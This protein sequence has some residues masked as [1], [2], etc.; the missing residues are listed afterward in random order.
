MHLGLHACETIAAV[1]PVLLLS[2]YL[3]ERWTGMYHSA[4]MIRRVLITI[5]ALYGLF[6][7]AL[8]IFGV[9]FGGLDGVSGILAIAGVIYA[10]VQVAFMTLVLF[11]VL[12]GVVPKS[13]R[14]PDGTDG[15]A[16]PEP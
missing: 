12:P 14:N 15:D 3:S 11:N 10:A 5:A 1:I 4:P 16:R 8:A 6:A 9:A 7:T 2:G 13:M